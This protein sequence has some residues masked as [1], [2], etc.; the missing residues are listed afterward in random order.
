MKVKGTVDGE[1]VDDKR[2]AILP[3][4]IINYYKRMKEWDEIKDVRT[5]NG[6]HTITV[7]I[8]NYLHTWRF[9]NQRS[10]RTGYWKKSERYQ[11]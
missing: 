5:S 9:T 10:S 2:T 6:G 7:R 3:V 8:S 1:K 4:I 11:S